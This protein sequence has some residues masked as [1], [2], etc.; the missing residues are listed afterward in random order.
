MK[1][2]FAMG[3]PHGSE[4]IMI[5]VLAFVIFGLFIWAVARRK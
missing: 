4:W 2:I 3:L 5:V 1:P